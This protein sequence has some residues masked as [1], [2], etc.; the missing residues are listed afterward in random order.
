M[1]QRL[2]V[3]LGVGYILAGIGIGYVVYVLDS[4]GWSWRGCSIDVVADE[5]LSAEKFKVEYG[6]SATTISRY[7]DADLFDTYRLNY[8][9]IFDGNYANS[10]DTDYGE[11]DFLLTYDDTYYLS[12]RHFISNTHSKHGYNFHLKKLGNNIVVSV[13]VDG[14]N[15]MQFEQ[16]MLEIK[17][18]GQYICN[19]QKD[20]VGTVYNMVDM[21]KRTSKQ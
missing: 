3:L 11:N 13:A 17:K 19:T 18:A 12:F 2:I 15:N 7:S 1:I 9:V 4:Q 14:R 20:S 5:G 6:L 8:N 10:F 16:P 21:K